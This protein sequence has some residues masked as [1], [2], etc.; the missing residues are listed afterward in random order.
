MNQFTHTFM[1]QMNT[2]LCSEDIIRSENKEIAL[3]VFTGFLKINM[4]SDDY[5]NL[6][7]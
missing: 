5:N 6:H 1:T 3:D 2:N 7:I 4:N